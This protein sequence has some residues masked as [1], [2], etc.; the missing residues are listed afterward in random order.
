[1]ANSNKAS[2]NSGY[3]VQRYIAV[4]QLQKPE[5]HILNLLKEQLPGMRMLD[6]GVGAGRTTLHFAH[7]VKEYVGFDYAENMVKACQ[8]RFPEI[9]NAFHLGDVRSMPEYEQ[10]TF[11]LILFSF[12]GLGYI[13]HEDR[14]KALKEIKR[15][16]KTGGYFVFSTHNALYINQLYR[17]KWNLKLKD[18]IYQ[19]YSL[20]MLIALNGLP[21]KYKKRPFAILND[22]TN[23]FSLKTYYMTPL[24]QIEQLNSLGFKNVRLFSS[25]TGNEIEPT[26]MHES[27]YDHWIYYLC[28]IS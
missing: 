28:E 22:G 6:I 21:G 11:D 4:D 18:F 17:F 23:R 13:D 7:L 5:Q 15:V 26:D 12:N 20:F 14:L 10:G 2:W 8:E 16:G 25:Q 3:V 1:M 24:A 27:G 9:K 19:F